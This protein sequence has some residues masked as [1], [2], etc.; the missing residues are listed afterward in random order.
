MK[1]VTDLGWKFW[2]VE[3]FMFALIS[4]NFWLAAQFWGIR[5]ADPTVVVGAIIIAASTEIALSVFLHLMRSKVYAEQRHFLSISLWSGL[6]LGCIGISIY[7]NHLFFASAQ[8]QA[9]GNQQV[10]LWIRSLWPMILLIGAA[11][12]PP[13]LLIVRSVADIQ[14]EYDSKQYEEQRK[15]DLAATKAR[16][17]H[18]RFSILLGAEAREKERQAAQKRR[19]EREG[20]RLKQERLRRRGLELGILTGQEEFLDFDW[21]EGQV[22]LHELPALDGMQQSAKRVA[23]KPLGLDQD[24][25]TATEVAKLTGWSVRTVRNRMKPEYRGK[26]AIKVSRKKQ[27]DGTRLVALKEVSRVLAVLSNDPSGG[28]SDPTLEALTEPEQDQNNGNSAVN[29]HAVHDWLQA[30][31]ARTQATP[32]EDEDEED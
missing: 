22:H 14:A 29:V 4:Y 11:F 3:V 1:R 17:Q 20:R 28:T 30:A 10:D 18:K 31:D 8:Y 5:A 13:K 16:G 21:L 6:S 19:D 15:Q 32:D 2:A 25:Y 24:F 26:W 9:E 7:V 23:V 12:V 27:E